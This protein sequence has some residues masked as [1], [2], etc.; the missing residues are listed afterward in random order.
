[1]SLRFKQI[2]SEKKE[3]DGPVDDLHE[4]GKAAETG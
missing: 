2:G 4:C 3:L 1:M